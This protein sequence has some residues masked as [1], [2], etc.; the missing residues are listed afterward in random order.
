MCWF[1]FCL[2]LKVFCSFHFHYF[3]KPKQY[4]LPCKWFWS[5]RYN[6]YNELE[7]PIDVNIQW[8]SAQTDKRSSLMDKRPA[9][10][11][12]DQ[13][14]FGISW[15]SKRFCPTR[16]EEISC[17]MNRNVKVC[18]NLMEKILKSL[19]D[20]DC[21]KTPEVVDTKSD[22][23]TWMCLSYLFRF[24][25]TIHKAERQAKMFSVCA[26]KHV[27]MQVLFRKFYCLY[28]Q[29]KSFET[30]VFPKFWYLPNERTR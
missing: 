22:E 16:C 10:K 18:N 6:I 27:L 25:T 12:L 24:K 8:H 4:V 7:F 20:S 5:C 28:L 14:E 11:C 17:K 13:W 2:Y 1:I 3:R 23:E 26:R 9:Q 19:D 29:I 21:P 30:I 15:A